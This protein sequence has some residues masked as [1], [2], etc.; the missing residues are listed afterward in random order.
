MAGD[1]GSL[2]RISRESLRNRIFRIRKN[3]FYRKHYEGTH[4]E[5]L[6]AKRILD[7]RG[8]RS[9]ILI[10]SPYHMRRIRLIAG[11]VFGGGYALTYVPARNQAAPTGA[12][13]DNRAG[14]RMVVREYLKTFWFFLH[15]PF[16]SS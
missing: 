15:A 4:V 12:D 13:W 3:V 16:I 2:E 5:A 9:A 11:T 14:R 7:E 8:F 6:E 1:D 10:S